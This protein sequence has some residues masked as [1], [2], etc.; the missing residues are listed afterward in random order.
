M[1][2]VH[3]R[4]KMKA[5]LR[6]E[7]V[8]QL[9]GSL[10]GIDDAKHF[11]QFGKGIGKRPAAQFARFM[12]R[13]AAELA[14]KRVCFGAKLLC[15]LKRRV[16]AQQVAKRGLRGGA[17]NSGRAEMTLTAESKTSPDK[18][19]LKVIESGIFTCPEGLPR[20]Q[21]HVASFKAL[22]P[23][24]KALAAMVSAASGVPAVMIPEIE[25]DAQDVMRIDFKPPKPDGGETPA[26]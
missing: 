24:A 10:A 14:V 19:R 2:R 11:R 20:E 18:F 9:S 3:Q 4:G 15:F 6:W 7:H 12:E 13:Y 16:L 21:V 25:L 26:D 8:K 23:Y 5:S 17:Q 22:F 1:R